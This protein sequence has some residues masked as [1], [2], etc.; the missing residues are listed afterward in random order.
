MRLIKIFLVLTGAILASN[1]FCQMDTLMYHGV[2]LRIIETYNVGLSIDNGAA[3]AYRVNSTIVDEATFYKFYV[4]YDSVANCCPCLRMH[5]DSSGTLLKKWIDCGG[6]MIGYSYEFNKENQVIKIEHFKENSTGDW[7][8]QYQRGLC[9]VPDGVTQCFDSTGQVA[10]EEHWSNGIFIHQIPEQAKAELWDLT[11]ILDSIELGHNSMISIA[12]LKILRFNPKYKNSNTKVDLE[13]DMQVHSLDRSSIL[14]S[15][16][17]TL[18][19]ESI[20]NF[21]F[22]TYLTDRNLNLENNIE[23][24]IVI[25]QRNF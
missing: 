10:Y 16:Y 1:L 11:L 14:W 8:N 25:K 13:I 6:C 22:Y 9:S 2:P 7:S 18:D 12:D 20:R 15:I 3:Q 4:G 21:N 17:D 19:I 24:L 23:F 5:R